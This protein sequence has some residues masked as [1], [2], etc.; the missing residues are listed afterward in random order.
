MQLLVLALTASP[1]QARANHAGM[2]LSSRNTT[3]LV[4][5]AF[6]WNLVETLQWVKQK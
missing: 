2:H 4:V 6:A 5:S 3:S 1:Q